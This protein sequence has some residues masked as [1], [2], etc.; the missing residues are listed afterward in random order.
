[1]DWKIFF[2]I[3]LKNRDLFFEF[4]SIMNEQI[5]NNS[6]MTNVFILIK[7]F[8]AKYKRVPD[9]DTVTLLLDKLPDIEQEHK[10]QYIDFIN[11]ISK[12]KI[13]IDLDVFRDELLRTIQKYEMEQF[14]LKTANK[15]HDV[16]FDDILGDIRT[17]MSKY[18]PK[19]MGID[20]TETEKVVKLIRHDVM[21]KVTS[22]VSDLDRN[23]YGGFGNNEI[24]IMM[25]PPGKG[26]SFFLINM[27]YGAL[28]AQKNVLYITLELSEKAVA[29]RLYGR[30]SHS[31]RK[32]MLE[33]DQIV[34]LTNK[35]F[36]LSQSRGR[37]VYYASK[38]LTAEGIEHLVE[39]QQIYFDF[40][41]DLLIVDYL[42]LLAPRGSYLRLEP[43]HR[44]RSVTEDLRSIS[45][46]HNIAVISATQANRASLSKLKITEA[47][48]SESFG[49]IEVADVVLALCQSEE[50]K[51]NKRARLSILKNRDYIS[52]GCVEVY[53]DFDRM[54]LMGLDL[55]NKLGLLQEKKDNITELVK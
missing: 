19:S 44:L 39:Q 6:V 43:R 1:M 45:L 33:E 53:V 36:T 5:F 49:K 13:N 8:V 7:K 47:N 34:K 38:S 42:D 3:F 4:I 54:L 41:P 27:M 31:S 50:E 11:E 15:I 10:K 22:G 23:L 51:Q 9:F 21:E 55:A 30:I 12:I 32:E 52:G 29:K 14:I 40:K 28:L 24:M 18:Q 20:I 46:R 37:I 16:K 2:H 26:K 35:F 48:V 17:I 25:A